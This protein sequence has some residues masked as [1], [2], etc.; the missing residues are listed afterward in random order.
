MSLTRRS[1]LAAAAV[2]PAARAL[3]ATPWPSALVMGTGQ[4]GDTFSSFGVAWGKIITAM[5]GVEIVY[6]ASGGSSANLLLIEQGAAQLGLSTLPIALQAHNGTSSWTAGVRLSQFRVLFPA[7]ASVLQI[8]APAAGVADVAGLSGKTLGIGPAEGS[9]AIL[10]QPILKSLGVTPGQLQTGPYEAQIHKLFTGEIAACAFFGAP[11]VAAIQKA[12]RQARLRLIGLSAQ[13]AEQVASV[14][15]GVTQ[16]ILKAGTFAG[17]STDVGSI[18]ML[19]L[20]V[21]AASLHESLAQSFTQ[22]ALRHEASLRPCREALNMCASVQE[23]E[24]AGLKFHPG[25]ALALKQAGYRVQ[26][27]A[28]AKA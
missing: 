22:A 27:D 21:G 8:V 13:Q 11:P 3:A 18:G 20:A 15:P 17:Q 4:P 10:M 14:V 25:A 24:A 16:M 12:A 1:L 28:I 7:Y 2:L 5:T 19:S 23:I 6:R 26:H 9:G